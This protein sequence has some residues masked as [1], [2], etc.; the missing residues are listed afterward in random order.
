MPPLHHPLRTIPQ[1]QLQEHS[2]MA[3]T[4]SGQPHVLAL[5]WCVN[6]GKVINESPSS[7]LLPAGPKTLNPKPPR[8]QACR[9]FERSALS[10]S[11]QWCAGCFADRPPPGR[12]ILW[13][14]S[15]TQRKRHSLLL[16][17][18]YVN[19]GLVVQLMFIA[20]W[21]LHLN[22]F[23]LALV[24]VCTGS[25]YSQEYSKHPADGLAQQAASR[26][27]TRIR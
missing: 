19:A 5:R 24:L 7:L 9:N 14:W 18:W 12:G 23:R 8:R 15:W 25:M 1:L 13:L 27:A 22:V 17:W 26:R 4:T 21:A 3:C 2:L 20:L 16:D 10:G 6:H 11:W